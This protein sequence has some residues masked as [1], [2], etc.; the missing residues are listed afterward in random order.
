MFCCGGGFVVVVVFS[1][2]VGPSGAA[3]LQDMSNLP[4]DVEVLRHAQQLQD[5]HLLRKLS[6]ADIIA[7]EA[8]YTKS[9]FVYS[10]GS[11][12]D[13]TPVLNKCE[14]EN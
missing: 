10:S 1:L 9:V 3:G 7:S 4:L 13:P 5:Q 12:L 6:P 2:F 11:N 8:K 14:D